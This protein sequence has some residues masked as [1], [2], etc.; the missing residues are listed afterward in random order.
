MTGLAVGAWEWSYPVEWDLAPVTGLAVET[1]E[2]LDWVTLLVVEARQGWA[3]VPVDSTAADP[4]Q[5]AALERELRALGSELGQDS[6]SVMVLA[7]PEPR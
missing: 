2:A 7:S 1:A 4:A 3:S 6:E 5:P